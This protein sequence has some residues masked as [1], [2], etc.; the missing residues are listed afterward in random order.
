VTNQ[1]GDLALTARR[2]T[3]AYLCLPTRKVV[4]P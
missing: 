3:S 1:F 2:K 4:L